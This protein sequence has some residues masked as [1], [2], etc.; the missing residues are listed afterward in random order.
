MKPQRTRLLA[1]MLVGMML[2][3]GSATCS[4]GFVTVDVKN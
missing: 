3:S 4:A 2:T 1:L